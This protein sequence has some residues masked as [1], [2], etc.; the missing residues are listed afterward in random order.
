MKRFFKPRSQLA[1]QYTP[2]VPPPTVQRPTTIVTKPRTRRPPRSRPYRHPVKLR[3]RATPMSSHPE[4]RDN[5]IDRLLSTP[6]ITVTKPKTRPTVKPKTGPKPRPAPKLKIHGKYISRSTGPRHRHKR[7]L[8][9]PID[10]NQTKLSRWGFLCKV[11]RSQ[12]DREAK[13]LDYSGSFVST[14]P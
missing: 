4:E 13:K 7:I 6:T 3:C 2:S 11:Q 14:T 1:T 12:A 9:P 5:S 8:Q 10:P